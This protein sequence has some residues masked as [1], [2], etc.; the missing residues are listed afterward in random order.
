MFDEKQKPGREAEVTVAAIQ[1]P[2]ALGDKDKNLNKIAELAQTAVKGGAELLV[3][4]ELC[5]SGYTFNSRQEVAE[6]AEDATGGESIKLFKKLARDLQAYMVFGFIEHEECCFYN[7]AAVV[8]PFGLAGIYRKLHLFYE[9]KLFFEPGNLGLPVFNLPWG[10]VGVLICYDLRFF[11]AGRILMLKGADII[12]VPTNW[13]V[14]FDQQGIDEQGY[15]MQ[16]YAAMV[17]ANTNQLYLACAN[18]IGE[19]R[20]TSFLGRSMIIGP[21]GWPLNGPASGDKEDILLSTVNLS[22]SRRGKIRNN[23]ND[24]VRDRRTDIYDEM[25]GYQGERYPF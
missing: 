13:V 23:L 11:E 16:N 18:R 14:L 8:G 3:F 2:V 12:C 7:S 20:G 15:C 22:D 17:M 1:M 6:L 5:T 19:E 9:E 21:T 10:K 4:P 24:L 25:L